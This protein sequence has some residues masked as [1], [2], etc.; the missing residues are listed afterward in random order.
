M[1]PQKK[2]LAL[3]IKVIGYCK[4]TLKRPTTI[5]LPQFP[6]RYAPDSI[7]ELLRFDIDN[8]LNYSI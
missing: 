5:S 1:S 3:L 8:D 4:K 7:A 6:C 2:P